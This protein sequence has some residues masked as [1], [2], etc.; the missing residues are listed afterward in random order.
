MKMYGTLKFKAA[1]AS[2]ILVP[3]CQTRR[4]HIV[5]GRY[6]SYLLFVEDTVISSY[7]GFTTIIICVVSTSHRSRVCCVPHPS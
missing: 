6:L 2:G 7:S 5:E 4:R 1:G 3:I